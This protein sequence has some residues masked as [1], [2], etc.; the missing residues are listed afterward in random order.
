[1]F[2]YLSIPRNN[3]IAKI[4]WALAPLMWGVFSWVVWHSS[5]VTFFSLRL[6]LLALMGSLV[7]VIS[8]GSYLQKALSCH[9][10]SKFI[11]LPPWWV[12]IILVWLGVL[13]CFTPLSG[14]VI[15][16]S[17]TQ[18][19]FIYSIF[20]EFITRAFFIRYQ[21][22]K[23]EFFLFNILSAI[24]FSLMHC[25]YGESFSQAFLMGHLEFSLCLSFIAYKTRRIELTILLHMIANIVNYTLPCIIFNNSPSIIVGSARVIFNLLFYACLIGCSLKEKNVEK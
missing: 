11:I 16:S 9:L 4:L 14:Y 23:K 5:V 22:G 17:I 3:L 15:V 10:Y 6:M 13:A 1:M 24:S 19:I 20:E 7:A 8:F 25:F 18:G 21:M 2:K 12:F